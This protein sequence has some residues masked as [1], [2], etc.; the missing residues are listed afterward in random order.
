MS[1]ILIFGL[2]LICFFAIFILAKHFWGKD[3]LFVIGIGGAIG[4]NIY[5]INSYPLQIGNFIFGF[6][7]IIYTFFIFC[8]L[9]M[10]INYGKESFNSILY[11]SVGSIFISA[12]FCWFFQWH[13]RTLLTLAF[14]QR[15]LSCLEG[16]VRKYYPAALL[17]DRFFGF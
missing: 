4:A 5:N 10:L 1:D 12:F 13:C 8:L 3:A 17:A 14:Q 16:L 7:S 15:M 9:V 11:S 6:D 2:V